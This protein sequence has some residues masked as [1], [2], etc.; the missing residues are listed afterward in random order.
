M[1]NNFTTI[2]LKGFSVDPKN[3]CAARKETTIEIRQWD[4]S[5]SMNILV[6]ELEYV[7]DRNE[8]I[9]ALKTG[10]ALQQLEAKR[11]RDKVIS[12]QRKLHEKQ[13]S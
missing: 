2:I 6:G 7:F 11:L 4:G 5:N 12:L 10:L 1:E 9:Q 8:I 3:T 13:K